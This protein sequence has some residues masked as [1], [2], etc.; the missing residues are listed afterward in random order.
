MIEEPN[1]HFT[2]TTTLELKLDNNEL[3][4]PD[5]AFITESNNKGF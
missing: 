4:K 1:N 2:S 5:A 3:N